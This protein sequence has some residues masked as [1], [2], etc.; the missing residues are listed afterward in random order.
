VPGV[1]LALLALSALPAQATPTIDPRFRDYYDTYQG[2]RVL[3]YARS[4]LVYIDDIAAQYFEKGRLEDH[5]HTTDDPTWAFMYGRLTAELMEHN[6]HG[7]VSGTPMVYNDLRLA[8]EP[9][10]RHAPPEGFSGGT[11]YRPEGVFVPYD[12]NLSRAPGYYVPE[13]FWRYIN[14]ADLFPGGWLHDVGL[15]MTDAFQVEASKNGELRTITM[16]AF[17]RAVLTYDPQNPP[18]WQIERANIGADAVEVL[19][20][21]PHPPR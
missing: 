8:A 11:L 18:E 4:E 13:R 10:Y 3:G 16:Q 12:G 9:C 5:R 21:A 7:S 1:L 17:E 14:R 20:L 19:P 15:P 6:P 2:V